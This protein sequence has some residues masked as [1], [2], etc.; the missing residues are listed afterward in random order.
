[1]LLFY[2]IEILTFVQ[3][4]DRCRLFLTDRV[5]EWW[6]C[7]E[8]H[9]W[10]C[11]GR[12]EGDTRGA[13]FLWREECGTHDPNHSHTQ[14]ERS[15]AVTQS[16][17]CALPLRHWHRTLT[18]RVDGALLF[19]DQLLQLWSVKTKTEFCKSNVTSKEIIAH[20]VLL[21]SWDMWWGNAKEGITILK[22]CTLKVLPHRDDI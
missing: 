17:W 12:D 19:L 22:L 11:W 5:H 7:R 9:H 15:N 8:E 14:G 10:K 6:V 18:E 4:F 2:H 13:W 1:M 20:I 21:W 16:Q 3:N